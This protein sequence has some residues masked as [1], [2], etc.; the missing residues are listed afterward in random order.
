MYT[1]HFYLRTYFSDLLPSFQRDYSLI[2]YPYSFPLVSCTAA[3]YPG[4][5]IPS[6]AAL[7]KLFTY[8]FCRSLLATNNIALQKNCSP[9]S[10][11][12]LPLCPAL[13]FF[14]RDLSLKCFSKCQLSLKSSTLSLHQEHFTSILYSFYLA[15]SSIQNTPLI[16]SLL[17]AS[18]T[19]YNV[20]Y[21]R[22]KTV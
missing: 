19:K 18:L 5:F 8:I 2:L 9:C 22:N 3:R 15:L 13:P 7:S 10:L 14:L 4:Q 17:L 6:H 16:H 12:Q 1:T 21:L 20:P 11:H